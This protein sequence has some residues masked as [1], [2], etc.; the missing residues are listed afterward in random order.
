MKNHGDHSAK[1]G[2]RRLK[3]IQKQTAL[4]GDHLEAVK[5]GSAQMIP[6]LEEARKWLEQFYSETV[7]MSSTSSEGCNLRWSEVRKQVRDGQLDYLNRE[8]LEYGAK[9]AWRNS[10]RCVGRL[11]WDNL[12]VRDLRHLHSPEQVFAALVDHI[13]L[14]TNRGRIVPLISVFAAGSVAKPRVRIWNRQ[15][16]GYAAYLEADGSV[17]GDPINLSFT[18]RIEALGWKSPSRGRFN[19]LPI[20][21]EMDGAVHWFNLP[22]D[23]ILEVPIRHPRYDWFEQLGLKW[24][25]LPAVSGMRLEIGG[26]NFPAAPFSGWYVGSEIGARDLADS[27]RYN[28]LPEVAGGLG[29][30]T[31]SNRSLWKDRALVELNEAVL[32]SF[33]EAGVAMVD[34]HT[35]TRQFLIHEKREKEAGRCVYADWSWMVPPISGAATPV[36]HRKFKERTLRPNF[37]RQAK[38]WEEARAGKCPFA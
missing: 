21:I 8:E 13:K 10:T 28:V 19:L 38:R 27:D 3:Q 2:S 35:V 7:G 14:S 5:G 1:I 22:A 33:T 26:V 30:D 6:L 20:V 16:I 12:A 34:H 31:D 15:L 24:F 32:W 37:F 18:Q 4:V 17:L 9:V 25:A 23:A 11:A 36:F 29:W